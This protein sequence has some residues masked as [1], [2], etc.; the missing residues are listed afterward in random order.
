MELWSCSSRIIH[1]RMR[2]QGECI[3]AFNIYFVILYTCEDANTGINSSSNSQIDEN[4]A[5]NWKIA[6]IAR[7]DIV[8]EPGTLATEAAITLLQ[9]FKKLYKRRDSS[10]KL[11][12]AGRHKMEFR[13]ARTDDVLAAVQMTA[14]G[15]LIGTHTLSGRVPGISSQGG[16]DRRLMIVGPAE[17]DRLHEIVGRLEEL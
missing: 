11:W 9:H 10:L 14:R 17:S 4:E 6:I 2:K 16:R 12:E 7:S 15:A 13:T 5:K 8:A 3:N 1:C